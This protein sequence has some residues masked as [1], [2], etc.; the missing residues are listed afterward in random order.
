MPTILVA[1]DSEFTRLLLKAQL[2]SLGAQILEAA[3]G[4][5][6]VDLARAT[7]PRVAVLDVEM[8]KHVGLSSSSIVKQTLAPGLGKLS[9]RI[10]DYSSEVL[11]FLSLD[12]R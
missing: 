7:H 12:K 9:S 1:D 10:R 5:A 11:K 2:E 3:D 8:P 6:A 4:Q